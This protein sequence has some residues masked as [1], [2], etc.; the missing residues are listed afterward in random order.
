MPHRVKLGRSLIAAC[1]AVGW[2]LV[3]GGCPGAHD[4]ATVP[5]PGG[6]GTGLVAHVDHV[7]DGDTIELDFGS[8]GSERVRLLGIDTPET[9]KPNAPVECFGPQASDR[10]KALL[11]EGTEVLVQRDE[12]ARDRYGRLLLHVWRRFDGLFVNRSL[13]VDGYATVLSIAPNKAHRADLAAAERTARAGSVGL[14]GTCDVSPG[15]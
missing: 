8:A 3:L 7:I 11:P 2:M 10:T 4:P 13:L 5:I 1:A 9:V 15:R 12:E 14:W 6:Y